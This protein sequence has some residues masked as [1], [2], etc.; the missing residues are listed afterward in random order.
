MSFW[1]LTCFPG[2]PCITYFLFLE[3]SKSPPFPRNPLGIFFGDLHWM[4]I[5]PRYEPHPVPAPPVPHDIR[6][7][8]PCLHRGQHLSAVANG[9]VCRVG[10]ATIRASLSGCRQRAQPKR[11]SNPCLIDLHVIS[12]GAASV[13][14]PRAQAAPLR[15]AVPLDFALHLI[16]F[17][18]VVLEII[19][20]VR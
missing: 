7:P 4:I 10:A 8:S 19:F 14:L 5:D 17:T 9:H 3:S 11:S 12:L 6:C 13:A 1:L 20:G 2:L 15:V 16:Q 18:F